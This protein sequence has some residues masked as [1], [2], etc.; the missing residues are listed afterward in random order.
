MIDPGLLNARQMRGAAPKSCVCA[1]SRLAPT[2]V[3]AL[4][5]LPGVLER[6]KVAF[7]SRHPGNLGSYRQCTTVF[8]HRLTAA[9]WRSRIA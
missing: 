5:A 8:A 1:T 7:G 3:S 9:W 4:S 6:S 2:H